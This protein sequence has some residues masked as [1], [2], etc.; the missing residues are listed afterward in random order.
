M[1][2]KKSMFF[3]LIFVILTSLFFT[4]ANSIH[5]IT[6][7]L[8]NPPDRLFAG[9]AHYYADYFLYISQF[10]QGANGKWIFSEHQFTNEPMRDFWIYWLNMLLGWIGARFGLN[11]FQS[12]NI[13]LLIFVFI[14]LLLWYQLSK[15]FY[16]NNRFKRLMSWFI[17]ISASSFFDF[18]TFFMT[19]K[20]EFIE[21]YWFSPQLS[22]VRLGGVPHQVFQTIIFLFLIIFVGKLLSNSNFNQQNAGDS[23]RGAPWPGFPLWVAMG[24]SRGR[25]RIIMNIFLLILLSFLGTSANAIQM[26][27]FMIALGL[28]IL[29]LLIEQIMYSI[30]LNKLNNNKTKSFYEVVQSLPI[31]QY[32]FIYIPLTVIA[33]PTLLLI[34]QEFTI[35]VSKYAHEWESII[36]VNVSVLQFLYFIGPSV[37]FIPFGIIPLLKSKEP[38]IRLYFF[39]GIFSFLFFFSPIPKL[40]GNPSPRFLHPASYGIIGILAVEGIVFI[41]NIV[42]TFIQSIVST[43]KHH[44]SNHQTSTFNHLSSTVYLLLTI[45]YLLLTVPALYSQITSRADPNIQNSVMLLTTDWN[46]I[47]KDTVDALKWLKQPSIENRPVVMMDSKFRM[48][49][50][51]PVLA[52]KISFSGHPIHTLYFAEKEA[53]RD[54]FFDTSLTKVEIQ[55]VMDD[56]R[57]GWIVVSQKTNP[58]NYFDTMNFLKRAFENN[59]VII[60]QYILQH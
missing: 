45:F 38:T 48:E 60:Y 12:Y 8:S 28:I 30:K 13:S 4:L 7:W 50:L 15:F 49:I 55:K 58:N 29:I 10:A 53:L 5:V 23:R 44:A 32:L 1:R 16:P 3:E 9:I 20:I 52:D 19:G 33:I 31:K 37:F 35:P 25:T 57:I 36:P 59:S 18:H 47:P 6:Q 46:H 14:L 22:F 51:V 26:M 56:H 42:R 54:R 41:S 21:Q 39:F 43:N 2:I 34:L 40:T 11:P 27:L 24:L 17:V